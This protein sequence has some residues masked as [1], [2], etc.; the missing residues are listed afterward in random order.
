MLIIG[1]LS[2]SRSELSIAEIREELRQPERRAD[3]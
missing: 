2:L 3:L 1:V